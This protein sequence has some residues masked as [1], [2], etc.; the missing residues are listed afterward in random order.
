MPI[1]IQ[2]DMLTGSTILEKFRHAQAL[3]VAGIEFWGTGLTAKVPEIALAM[4]ETGI[5]AAA[6]NH[7][8]QGNLLD[9]D[10]AE[11]ERALAHL[12]QSIVNAV[13]IGAAGV[14]FVPHFGAPVLPDLSPWMS[15]AELEAE[16]LHMHLRTLSDYA[17]ALGVDL[18]V[19]PINRYET[20][21]L[22]RLEQA[23]RVTRRLNHPRVKIVADLFHMALEETDTAAAIHAHAD[24]IGH[25]HLADHNRRLPG[26]GM[27]DFAAAAAALKAIGYTGW[28]AYECGSSSKS[29]PDDYRDRLPASL[30]YL[31]AAGLT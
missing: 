24:C 12:R 8:W 13:D 1:A 4:A 6:V 15:S 19:E 27:I 25:V 28:L 21:L 23:A 22:N 26:E 11:R 7:G 14:I 17:E 31:R 2:E 10:P 18:Y 20:H 16:M 5:R 3:G 29:E 9:P 30:A